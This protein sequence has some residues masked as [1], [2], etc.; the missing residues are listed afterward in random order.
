MGEI[1]GFET[2]GI[3]K[4]Q[5][6]MDAHLATLPNGGQ[7]TMGNNWAAGDIMYRDLNGDGKIDWGNS[8]YEDLAI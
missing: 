2:M 5:E 1:W 7:N 3:A 6:E 8:T 4:T